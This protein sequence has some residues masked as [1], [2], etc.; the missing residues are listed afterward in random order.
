MK[1]QSAEWYD[2]A[3]LTCDEMRRAE[4]LSVARGD[5]SFFDLMLRAGA[6]VAR[7]LHEAYP[8][9]RI[10]VLCG[11]GNNGGDGYV[12]AQSLLEKGRAVRLVA[13]GQPATEDAAK[14]AACWTGQTLSWSPDLLADADIVIDALF[15][16]GL[17]RPL[18]G[19]FA[20]VIAAVNAASVKVVSADMPSG[21][22]GDTGRVLGTAIR[23]DLSVTFFRLK[24][25]H[26]LLDGRDYAG[27]AV[28]VDTGMP[29]DVLDEVHPLCVE[30]KSEL[31][32]TEIPIPQAA[33]H[34]YTRGHLIVCGGAA[35]TGAARLAARAA[36]RAGAGLVS[37]IAPAP[38][39]EVYAKALESVIVVSESQQSETL[40]DPKRNVCLIGP[41]LGLGEAERARVLTVLK[42]CKP[43]VLDA[44][45]LS[46][47]AGDPDTLFAMLHKDCIL[48]PHEG[49]F[50]RLF[51]ARIDPSLSKPDRALAAARM[52]G[53]IVLLK[54]AD[55]VIANP[56]G[57]CVINTN[58]P[59]WLATGGAGD[60]LAGMIAGL[61]AQG[62]EAFSAACAGAYIHGACAHL[63][64]PGL[65]AED[66]IEAL[67]SF[68]DRFYVKMIH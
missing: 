7:V 38:A 55:T 37:L 26:V 54:G 33:G 68:W 36:Q 63:H 56:E 44:D 3:L 52:S 14:A 42:T 35:M 39:W 16:T 5:Q 43:T 31:W 29:A 1:T 25:G 10:L 15:G 20:E 32:E 47:F 46:N 6:G 11:S 34:K 59:A 8:T 21:I 41:G 61:L 57:A 12:A 28:I 17:S 22:C 13:L 27:R 9:G 60:V 50:F 19:L 49:E 18:E 64:G 66:L 65:I 2:A 23:A 62:M 51:G 24:R 4:A 53:C 67:P 40:A 45:A 48:T 30:N 58:A